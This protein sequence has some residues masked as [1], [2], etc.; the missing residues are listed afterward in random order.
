MVDSVDH[1]SVIA[2]I[3]GDSGW[4][5]HFVFMIMMS[6]GIA[7]LGLL[8]SSPAVVIGAMLI[9]PLMG[10]IIG[11]GFAIA[12]FDSLW[13]RQ[14][15]AAL[16]AGVVLATAF[17]VLIVWF[18][19]LQT[20]TDEIAARTRPNLFDLLVALFSGLA[21]T[22]AMIR[23]RHGTIVGVAIAT[24][25][26]PPLAVV[27]FGL[28]T[29]NWTVLAGSFLLFFTNLMTIAA[30]AALLARIYGFA[31]NLS[32]HQTRLQAVLVTLT[33]AALAVPLALALKQ[34]AWEA[35]ASR[36]AR[37]TI[38]ARFGAGSRV[39]ELDI[40]FHRDPVEIDATVLTAHYDGRAERLLTIALEKRLGRPV[41]LAIDQLRT[42]E[43]DAEAAE[44]AAA[45]NGQGDRGP[46]RQPA[47]LAERLALI[48]GVAPD[49]ILMDTNARRALVRAAP[50]PGASLQTY[51]ELEARVART[52]ASWSIS[53]IPPAGELPEVSFAGED[54]DA[55]GLA[56]IDTAIWA[57][58]RLSLPVGIA[59]ARSADAGKVEAALTAAGIASYRTRERPRAGG[60]TLTWLAPGERVP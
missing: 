51:R 16:L 30:S 4:S 20:V 50:L 38:S 23:G 53:L 29:A 15:L 8:L 13:M 5:A 1:E 27:G 49:Q 55:A 36:Q 21:G 37:E 42:G 12:T 52:D 56:A 34:I 11:L 41:Q 46:A 7:V 24:A 19:P 17:C 45:K 44:L 18:S 48:A 39:S 35:V 60:V 47:R 58:K 3:G 43:G 14:S 28:A 54:P 25:L 10:P 31:Q 2:E 22:Y 9:S 40:D 26:M 59:A 33:L 57:A 6:A 32:P